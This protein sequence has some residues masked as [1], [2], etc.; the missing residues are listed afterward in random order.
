MTI[1]TLFSICLA[2]ASV[3]LLLAVAITED[4]RD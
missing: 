1:D 2:A 3:L 4:G